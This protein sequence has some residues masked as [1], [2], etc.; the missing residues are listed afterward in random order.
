MP[1]S[2]PADIGD[3]DLLAQGKVIFEET[4]GGVGC[5]FCHGFEGKGDGVADVGAPANAGATL[6][7]FETAVAEGESGAMEYIELT[8]S[9][10]KA[11]IAYLQ[12]LGE[13][14]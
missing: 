7:L 13:Q 4:G 9:E 5:A 2:P 8:S 6:A 3:N 14:N 1:T 12:F 10:K 11:V